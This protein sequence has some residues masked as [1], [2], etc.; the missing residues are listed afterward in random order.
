MQQHHSQATK[1]RYG[2]LVGTGFAVLIVVGVTFGLHA[3]FALGEKPQ[4]RQPLTVETVEYVIQDR[5]QR[6]VQEPCLAFIRAFAPR[7]K[8]LSRRFEASDRRVG[9]SLMRVYRDAR[10]AKGQASYKTNVGI[11]F[12]HE[13]GRDVHAP[14]F[15]VHIAPDECFLGLGT[16]HPDAAALKRIRRAIVEQPDRW[17]RATR[18]R[19]FRDT[20]SLEGDRLRRPPQGFPAEHPL[21]EDLK[22]KDFVGLRPSSTEEVLRAD[23]A[24]RVEEA[25]AAGRPLVRFLC[26]ALELPF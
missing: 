8:R 1:S 16:W 24:Q 2:G 22:W 7:L 17:R 26:Q 21:V 3:R 10:F 25:F 19:R 5:Y 11:Q 23:F 15:Y 14:G 13:S 9:G 6:D 12:R 18:G 20:F 4:P